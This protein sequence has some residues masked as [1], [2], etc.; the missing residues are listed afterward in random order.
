MLA[1]THTACLIC[2]SRE[3]QPLLSLYEE[4]VDHGSPGHSITYAYGV[5][6]ACQA[7]GRGQLESFSHDCFHYYGDE[8]W[9]MFFWFALEPPD[10]V[11]L[12]DALR[13]CPDP[14]DA[15]CGCAPHVSLRASGSHL[16]GG[17]PHAVAPG[18]SPRFAWL[19]VEE[20][21]DG[22]ALALSS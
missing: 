19:R 5:L 6:A 14:Q 18:P 21:A 8:D 4:G 12:R 17:I 11:R 22:P 1:I 3:L 10:V 13:G 9:D 15:G 7:C 20:H 16:W 2:G